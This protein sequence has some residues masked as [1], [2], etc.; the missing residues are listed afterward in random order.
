[1]ADL[2]VLASIPNQGK[3]T[4]ALLL[5]KK[6][7]SEGKRVACLQMNKDNKDVYRY[8][9]EGCYHYTIPFEA[10][11]TREAFERWVPKGYDSYILEL[12][13]GFS[14][15][16]IPYITL[17]DHVN[18][19]ISTDLVDNWKQH[20]EQRFRT[21]WGMHH[22]GIPVP[23]DIMSLWDIVHD[24][25]TR[26][27][28]TKTAE[29][30]GPSVDQGMILHNVEQLAV[31]QVKP[32]ME[33][34]TSNKKVVSVGAFPA[35][36]WDIFPNHRWFGM[37]YTGFMDTVRKNKY[38]LVIIGSCGAGELKLKNFP[39]RTPAICYQPSVFL[40]LEYRKTINPLTG[41]FRSIYDTIKTKKPGT[42]L[43]PDGEPFSGYNNPY[44]VYRL[45][46]KPEVVWKSG[47]VVYCNGWVL[48]QY[49]IRDGFL[50]VN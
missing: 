10:S 35:E 40:D 17:F 50:E 39:D 7:K 26:R 43:A 23:P 20:A 3:T 2:Y 15:V 11:Q 21:C 28:I 49:L 24:R 31:E 46:E 22:P 6:L 4:T 5:E 36:Y 9:S 8:L 33:F 30:K 27:V 13:Y 29:P 16:G 42:P 25:D 37:E 45:Y 18:E 44:W 34:P 19:L 47:S 48:P 38:D 12:S 14:P 32:K 1:M 41:G